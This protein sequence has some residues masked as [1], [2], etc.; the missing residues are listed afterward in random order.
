MR[1]NMTHSVHVPPLT[2]VQEMLGAYR[3]LFEALGIPNDMPFPI[4]QG[5]T[6]PIE[7]ENTKL[8]S[9]FFNTMTIMKQLTIDKVNVQLDSTRVT[10][11]SVLFVFSYNEP[12]E[13]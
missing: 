5:F 1:R 12:H 4:S 10:G 7:A 8:T 2:D 9:A 3:G 11:E 13:V 6:H